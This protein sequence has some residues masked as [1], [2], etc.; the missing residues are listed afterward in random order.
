[1]IFSRFKSIRVQC[2]Q[3]QSIL[4]LLIVSA[5]LVPA[6]IL[7]ARQAVYEAWPQ[8]QVRFHQAVLDVT[9]NRNATQISGT[10]RYEVSPFTGNTSHI[11][12]QGRAMTVNGAE[13]DGEPLDVDITDRGIRID[14]EGRMEPGRKYQLTIAYEATPGYGIHVNERGT[15][16][17]SNMPETTSA[18]VPSF[19]SP[20]LAMPVDFSFTIPDGLELVSVGEHSGSEPAA[21]GMQR[22][23]WTSNTPVA[24]S[25][26]NFAFGDLRYQE[27]ISGI[28]PVR[29]YSEPGTLN[30]DDLNGLLRRV[31]DAM[32]RTQRSLNMEFPFDG[33]NVLVL[34]DHRWEEKSFAPGYG[35]LFQNMGDLMVQADR[36]VMHQWFGARHRAYDT[37]TA[38]VH[39]AYAAQLFRE[40]RS[41]DGILKLSDFPAHEDDEHSFYGPSFWNR[42]MRSW[43]SETG[44]LMFDLF[45]QTYHDAARLPAGVYDL[46]AYNRFW[47]D[48]IGT[49]FSGVNPDTDMITE[50]GPVFEIEITE[51]ESEDTVAFAVTPIQNVPDSVITI[52]MHLNRPDGVEDAGFELDPSGSV[53]TRSVD[54]SLQNITFSADE[55]IELAVYKPFRFWLHQLRH[56]EDAAERAAAAEVMAFFTDDPDLQ[57]ALNDIIR[58]EEDPGVRAGLVRAMAALTGGASGTEQM[59]MNFLREEPVA[60]RLDALEALAGYPGNEEVQRM[61]GRT[62]QTASEPEVAIAALKS[63]RLISNEADFRDFVRRL[64]TSDRQPAVKA[65]AL[66]ELFM[67]VDP[68]DAVA[69]T[70][71]YL[72]GSQPY[73]VRQTAFRLITANAAPEKTESVIRAFTLDRDPRIRHIALKAASE[74]LSDTAYRELLEARSPAEPDSRVG[75]NRTSEQ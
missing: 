1:M 5:C 45:R 40:L 17:T 48:Q 56:S 34:A 18:W 9:I 61:A 38:T 63:L 4:V 49:T 54:P 72:S 41:E 14:T 8:Q 22:F 55:S 20:F 67:A 26:W 7:Q 65:A 68:Q 32:G 58:N 24:V 64:M 19:D 35:Y 23:R 51:S 12:L 69:L 73:A 66:E 53:I 33:L 16:W 10:V 27:A 36:A 25:G 2:I 59:F 29:V 31:S 30:A 13:L 60:I 50:T 43:D 39:Q 3:V 42:V 52:T 6:T 44:D 21:E 62:V 47:Y 28:K 75:N 57:L 46:N 74:H 11:L 71:P 70:D 15:V 37:V